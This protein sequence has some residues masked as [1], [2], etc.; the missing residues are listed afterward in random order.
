MKTPLFS[1]IIPTYNRRD[2][3]KIALESVLKQTFSDYEIIVVD[4]GSTDNTKEI[5]DQANSEK[6]HYFYQENQGPAA[7]RNKGIKQAKGEFISFL[8]SD[9]RFCK[10]KLEVADQYIKKQPDYQIFH[11][12]E[13]WYR[14]GRLLA[15]KKHHQK[16]SGLVFEQTTKL[17]CISPSTTVI[18]KN[19]FKTIGYFDENLLACEDYDF[20]LRVSSQ[21]PVFL[22]PEYL[23]IKEGGHPDQQSKK[24]P[25]MDRFR[26]YALE[27]ILKELPEESDD[28]RLAWLELRRKCLIYI[29]GAFGFRLNRN[30]LRDIERLIFEISRRQN[31]CPT[32]I[33]ADLKVTNFFGLKKALIARRFPRTTKEEKI[34]PKGVFLNQLRTPL[35]NNYKPKAIFKPEKIFVEKAVKKSYLVDNFRR[36]FPETK[37]E[38]LNYYSD[39]LKTNK[40]SLAEL[41]KPYLFIVKEKWDFL[42]PCPCTKYHLGCGYWI[43]NLGFGCPYDCS[44]C[45][46]QHYT[47]F[48]GIILP[49]NL[50]DFFDQFDKFSQKLKKPIRIGTGEFS[51]SLALDHLTE[52]SKELIPYFQKKPVLFEL[53]TK[54]ANI[55]NLLKL[56]ASKNIIISWSLNPENLIDSQEIAVAT[57]R[58]RL[59]A[60]KRV[61]AAGYGIGFHFDPIIHYSSW[62][63]DYQQLIDTLYSQLPPPFAWISLG[64]LRSNRQL[65]TI[66]EMRFPKSDIFYGE[67]LIGEDKKLR[68]PKALRKEIYPAMAGWIRKYDHHT[69]IYLCMESK[70][71]WQALGEVNKPFLVQP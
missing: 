64:T 47:N 33:V 31:I 26:I 6:I 16:P 15:Q 24:Y 3:F 11:T 67:L 38:E 8:D 28:Y 49:G 12:E 51:D 55:D 21:Y 19:V 65:K 29:K 41:K 13:I 35:K 39:Y 53:K 69:P 17:C 36:R 58:E 10:Q 70:D 57:L 23:T 20:W 48:P 22:I 14:N 44:Y 66:T 1:V 5:V 42:K 4:D 9:D 18:R 71:V 37:I 61:Q 40:F 45:F 32:K 60:A 50:E 59:K 63:D 46:L 27:K 52:Y 62:K 25:A 2:F 68:Y 7:A 34:E 56:K 54:S 30:Q 43:L